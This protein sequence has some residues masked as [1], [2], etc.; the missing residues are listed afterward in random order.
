MTGSNPRAVEFAMKRR[1]ARLA[2]SDARGRPHVVP[3]CYVFDG[4]EIFIA[5]DKKPKSVD[6][7]RLKRVRNILENPQVSVVVD[8]YS[9]NWE[10]LG[11]VII[12]GRA[13]LLEWGAEQRRAIA[14]LRDK[15]EQYREMEI[16]GSP[17]IRI[18][19]EEMTGW[20]NLGG[21]NGRDE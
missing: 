14:M 6:V 12:H 9:E 3:I 20:G 18:V 5:L 2:T 11:F 19:V 15:Y 21:G 17:V 7:R 16:D 4:S 1:V 8:D 13:R 10:K